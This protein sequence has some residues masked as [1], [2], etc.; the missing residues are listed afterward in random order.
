[1]ETKDGVKKKEVLIHDLFSRE[2]RPIRNWHEFLERWQVATT[3]EEMLGLLHAGFNVQ[4][5]QCVGDDRTYSSTDRLKFYFRLADGWARSALSL[6]G[7]S[8][9]DREER[10]RFGHDQHGR[11]IYRSQNE[12]RQIV[13]RKAF[14]L[15][16]TNFFS[17]ARC[18]DVV[19]EEIWS[20]VKDFFRSE[21]S[22]LARER[23]I[24][25]N[26]S[27]NREKI[28]HQETLAVNF[29][30]GFADFLWFWK[31]DEINDWD[32][33]VCRQRKVEYNLF[34]RT[35]ISEAMPWLIEILVFLKRLDI[36]DPYILVLNDDCLAK[37]EEIT[38]RSKLNPS[39]HPVK[40]ERPVESLSEAILA[41]SLAAN[42]LL[43]CRT[44]KKE[45]ER[46]S[47]IR[48]A[49]EE[50]ESARRRVEELRRGEEE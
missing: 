6:L 31:K 10:Y 29:L 8:P 23:I 28:S 40:V 25:R 21:K 27:A 44:M 48:E 19:L 38:K 30:L 1:M 20:M 41:G 32:D 22:G 36:L 39:D 45:Y 49:E 43:R 5:D 46:L 17:T 47:A 24:I 13:A 3:L 35:R 37:L 16:S 42:F 11:T 33:K 15:L 50:A 34:V 12:L 18:Q 7:D 9:E 26:L 14:D 4:L 2:I